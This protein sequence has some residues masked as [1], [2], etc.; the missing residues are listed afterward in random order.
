MA[1][2]NRQTLKNYF[3]KGGFATERHF[4]DLIDSSL[5][6]VDDGLAKTPEHG[7][8]LSPLSNSTKLLSFSKRITQENPDYAINLNGNNV[9][10]LSIDNAENRT[11]IKF[12]KFGHVGLNTAYP[13]H[14]FDVDGTIGFKNQIGTYKTGQVPADGNWHDVLSELDGVCAFEITASAAG[15]V[16]EG[17]YSVSHALAL[18]TYGGRKSRQKIRVTTAYYEKYFRKLSFR[19]AGEMY[20]YSLQ[21]RT[22]TNYGIDPETK[23]NYHIRFNV[24]NLLPEK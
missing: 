17:F 8:K 21:I 14:T 23:E 16:G 5:N 4:I 9:E 22:K 2:I 10:G 1:L 6:S 24:I 13:K 15:R 12:N 7:L 18:S 11:L 20:N 3:K 19:W